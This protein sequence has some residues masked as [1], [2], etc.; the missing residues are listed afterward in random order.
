[1]DEER[2][3]HTPGDGHH[4]HGEHDPH[5]WLGLP[6]AVIMVNCIRDELSRHRSR[7]QRRLHAAG[8]G[9]RQGTGG[10]AASTAEKAAWLARRIR[11][12]SPRTIH[13]A[14]SPVL[15]KQAQV[16]IVGNI[17]V[18]AGVSTDAAQLKALANLAKQDDIRVIAIEPQFARHR[19]RQSPRS[20]KWGRRARRCTD[21][22]NRS[23]GDSAQRGRPGRRHLHPAQ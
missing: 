10:P 22:R 17:Q 21:R 4:H 5:V 15:L 18:R 14:T 7:A 20:A 3:D 16:E 11:T 9:L 6:E 13:C 2:H 19:P 1:M 12:S 8:R 23:A